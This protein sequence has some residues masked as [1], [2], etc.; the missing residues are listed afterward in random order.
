[1]CHHKPILISGYGRHQAQLSSSSK[2]AIHIHTS[3]IPSAKEIWS[4]ES[5]SEQYTC[6]PLI[7]ASRLLSKQSSGSPQ[8][9]DTLERAPSLSNLTRFSLDAAALTKNLFD[10]ASFQVGL[11]ALKELLSISLQLRI[12]TSHVDD[13]TQGHYRKLPAYR[14]QHR[15]ARCSAGWRSRISQALER[16]RRHALYGGGYELIL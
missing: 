7:D 10:A 1:M 4:N 15:A 12:T 9:I 6:G 8:L 5:Y 3:G 13:T 16:Y 14:G 11:P 2:R